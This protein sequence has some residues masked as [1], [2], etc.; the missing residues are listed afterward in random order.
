MSPE[1]DFE[2][3]NK[4]IKCPGRKEWVMPELCSISL[5]LVSATGRA[6]AMQQRSSQIM[7][8]TRI[9]LGHIKGTFQ[10]FLFC[11]WNYYNFFE[12]CT[13]SCMLKLKYSS[14][15]V[16]AGPDLLQQCKCVSGLQKKGCDLALSC[17][18]LMLTWT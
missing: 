1:I 17:H 8:C 3:I 13:E 4:G 15:C 10:S 11:N 12:L 16:C 6:E 9:G 18:F 5:P 2:D 14:L 7:L